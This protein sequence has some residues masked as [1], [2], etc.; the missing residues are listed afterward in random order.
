MKQYLNVCETD[1]RNELSRLNAVAF[2]EARFKNEE[3][4]IKPMEQRAI[5]LYRK[6]SLVFFFFIIGLLVLAYAVTFL[7]QNTTSKNPFIFWTVQNHLRITIGLILLSAI[8]GYLP[9]AITYRHL[10]KT[11][12]E[13]QKLLDTVFL[14][15]NPEEREV[16]NHLVQQN[17]LSSQAEIS[18]LPGMSRVKAFRS[19]K[20]MHEKNLLDIAVHGKIRKVALKENILR[21]LKE[22]NC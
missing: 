11:K 15:L 2:F 17:G 19:L 20:K 22:E 13:S 5:D 10:A 3:H 21:M 1:H 4:V 7:H 14:F 9:S 12:K 6:I 18:R 16:I 8:L